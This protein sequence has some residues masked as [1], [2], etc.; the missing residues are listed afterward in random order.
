M[1]LQSTEKNLVFLFGE[2]SGS[3]ASPLFVHLLEFQLSVD[4]DGSHIL[5]DLRSIILSL[6][7]STKWHDDTL[8]LDL[9]FGSLV[10]VGNNTLVTLLRGPW[11]SWEDDELLEI[12]LKSGNVS[13][14]ALDAFISSSVVDGDTN[15]PGKVFIESGLFDLFE[16][17]ASA[18][19]GSHVVSLSLTSDGWSECFEWSRV[20][21][22]G[23]SSS[24]VDGLG[25]GPIDPLILRNALG[26]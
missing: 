23:L 5:G 11:V 9:I 6:S 3:L 10:G 7:L 24:L 21:S 1:R 20:D 14:E 4:L 8:S 13:L 18:E 16:G 22:F 2:E 19:S 12:S 15:G 26:S 25:T 17:E